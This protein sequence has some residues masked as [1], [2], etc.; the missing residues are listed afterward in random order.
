MD[1]V[2]ASQNLSQVYLHG[3]INPVEIEECQDMILVKIHEAEISNNRYVRL[4]MSNDLGEAIIK[5]EFI[6]CVLPS[7]SDSEL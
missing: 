5:H 3:D 7:N 4:N 6:V 1:S 2:K